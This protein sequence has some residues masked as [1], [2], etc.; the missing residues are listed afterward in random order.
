MLYIIVPVFNRISSTLSFI[1]SLYAQEFKNF[2]L[3]VVDDGSTDGTREIIENKYPKTVILEGSGDL[4]WGG[5]IN[6]GL[7]YVERFARKNDYI[8][9]ANNDVI[10]DN[11][12]IK[13]L[14]K[15]LEKNNKGIYHCV[16]ISNNKAISSGAKILNWPFFIT[17]HPFRGCEY[18]T[19]KDKSN[20]E[21]DLMTARFVVFSIRILEK[22]NRIDEKNFIHYAGDNDFSLTLKKYNIK[23]FIVPNS[24]CFV[25][26]SKTGENPRTIRYVK[27]VFN[28]FNSVRS[29]N[30]LSV[31]FKL[32][33]KHCPRIYLPFYCISVIL[34]VLLLNV[35]VLSKKITN[36]Q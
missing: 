2:T 15:E 18:S 11:N 28:S 3:I 20:V 32:G 13:V 29:T 14:V 30:N 24:K 8:A 12:T 23:T 4:F 27:Q 33:L 19:I 7:E 25:D 34:Q 26:E 10:I 16:T 22:V 31:R 5:G 17:R 35:L 6:R 1:K 21:I 36:D 9:F